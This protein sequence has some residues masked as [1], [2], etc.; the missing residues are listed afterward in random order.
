MTVVFPPKTMVDLSYFQNR[1]MTRRRLWWTSLLTSQINVGVFS[2]SDP[3]GGFET[4]L[5]I[6]LPV[7]K[8]TKVDFISS[9]GEIP[10]TERYN[11]ERT[12]IFSCSK[13]TPIKKTQVT[14]KV[15]RSEKSRFIPDT[16]RFS[17]GSL[18]S[19]ETARKP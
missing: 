13:T 19:G 8:D 15:Q 14:V 10:K 2:P 18:R 11:V 5:P 1:R 4:T 6:P 16:F 17:Y 9:I 7:N 3:T 12:K